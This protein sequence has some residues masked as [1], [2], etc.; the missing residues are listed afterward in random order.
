M[1][2]MRIE[3]LISRPSKGALL[4]I[5]ASIIK[6]VVLR[7]HQLVHYICSIFEADIIRFNRA[8]TKFMQ[9]R[10][11]WRHT[12]KL[13]FSASAR[14]SGDLSFYDNVAAS[15]IKANSY[16]RAIIWGIPMA[17]QAPS[18]T[19]IAPLYHFIFDMPHFVPHLHWRYF[20]FYSIYTLLTW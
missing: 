18:Q 17:S 9:N 12:Y 14:P 5:E 4:E 7:L 2:P 20:K 3:C 6:A 13:L 1:A 19:Y 15:F 11:R 8:R 16:S 10:N